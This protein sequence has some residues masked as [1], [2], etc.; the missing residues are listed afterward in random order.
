GP[1]F[2]AIE[3]RDKKGNFK[4]FNAVCGFGYSSVE[5]VKPTKYSSQIL[6]AIRNCPIDN[7]GKENVMSAVQS[8]IGQYGK[9]WKGMI[10]VVWTDESGDDIMQL[11]KTI[12]MCRKAHAMVLVV[13]PSA[14]LGS[15]RGTHYW[16]DKPTGF[17]FRLP[18]TR[19]P[20]TALP[21]KMLL[22]Y[23]HDAQ[24]P[25]WGQDGA[26]V[27]AGMPWYGGPHREGLLSGI[28]PWALTRLALQT[29][30][31]FTLLDHKEDQG[32]FKLAKLQ[33][34]FP[35]YGSLDEYVQNAHASPLRKA[36]SAAVQITYQE[37]NMTTP[38][39]AFIL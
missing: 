4:L 11:E 13:G 9:S 19:G 37:T 35:S 26:Q 15:D 7:S 8:V 5:L 22:P 10:I 23:W 20:D 39:T 17:A 28:G 25:A 30:G 33:R 3:D 18:V 1:Y 31:R 27:A 2:R 24:L 12:E 16:V 6:E 14:V 21:E 34:Y 29:G 36:V 32:P 38:T